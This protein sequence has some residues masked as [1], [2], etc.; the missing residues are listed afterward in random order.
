MKEPKE[1]KCIHC[2]G[3]LRKHGFQTY[4]KGG[5]KIRTQQYECIACF[6]KSAH[7]M[8]QIIPKR[9]VPRKVY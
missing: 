7:Y 8:G 2:G 9:I 5:V 3:R 1:K 6:K 4:G